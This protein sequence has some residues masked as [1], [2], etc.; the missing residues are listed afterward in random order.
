M[1]PKISMITLGVRDLE[2]SLEFY[3]DGLGFE[4]HNYK[5][6]DDLVMFVMD[7]SWLGLYPREALAEDA[8]VAGEGSGFAGFS[9]AHNVKSKAEVDEV[10]A[11]A[12]AAGGRAVK[13]PQEVFWGGYSG[14][15]ADPDG[16]L[17]EV[18]F[19]PFTDLS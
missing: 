13:V 9:L 11:F 1:R 19:N 15:F 14:Y 18:A 12:V 17:W 5:S 8:Q 10:F 16:F 6:G 4:P 2:R 7:G 3:R